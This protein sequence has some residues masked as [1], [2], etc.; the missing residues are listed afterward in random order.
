MAYLSPTALKNLKKYAYKGVDEYV[1]PCPHQP[2][3]LTTPQ[4]SC[5]PIRPFPLLELVHHSLAAN[6]CAEYRTL[7]NQ[8]FSIDGYD[9]QHR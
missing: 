6:S 1:Y 4:V 2:Q 5:I 7:L 3:V 9:M 8:H